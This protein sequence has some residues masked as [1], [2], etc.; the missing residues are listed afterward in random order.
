M[1]I[2]TVINEELDYKDVTQTKLSLDM[3]MLAINGKERTEEEWKKT[4]H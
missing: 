2:E 4:L 3:T 1:I